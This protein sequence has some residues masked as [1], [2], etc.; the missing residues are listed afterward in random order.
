MYAAQGDSSGPGMCGWMAKWPGREQC[1]GG[2]AWGAEHSARIAQVGRSE[3]ADAARTS[4]DTGPAPSRSRQYRWV[5]GNRPHDQLLRDNL[6]DANNLGAAAAIGSWGLLRRDSGTSRCLQRQ[7][8]V[9]S[10]SADPSVSVDDLGSSP[11][12]SVIVSHVGFTIVIRSHRR[13]G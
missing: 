6:D 2:G 3:T 9:V 12:R 4:A 10:C 11:D 13:R 1:L 5:V 8:T 7:G